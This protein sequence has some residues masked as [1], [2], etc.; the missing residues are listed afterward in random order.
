MVSAKE[1]SFKIF[2]RS[3][4][5]VNKSDFVDY[6]VI[7]SDNGALI[8]GDIDDECELVNEIHKAIDIIDDKDLVI[9]LIQR[10]RITI[11]E[12]DAGYHAVKRLL[13]PNFNAKEFCLSKCSFFVIKDD[14]YSVELDYDFDN[15]LEVEVSKVIET[16]DQ[17]LNFS[18]SAK[19]ILQDIINGLEVSD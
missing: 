3:K 9:L 10:Y 6:E 7:V 15:E 11:N 13:T 5:R 14:T 2:L 19:S 12:Q 17:A 16:D 8:T 4:K 1:E 18:K